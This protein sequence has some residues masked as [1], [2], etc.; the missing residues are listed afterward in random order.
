MILAA[1]GL[2]AAAQGGEA[3][4]ANLPEPDGKP[5]RLVLRKALVPLDPPK[6]SPKIFELPSGRKTRFEFPWITSAFGR[7]DN[8]TEA[9]L[10]MRVYSQ[11]RQTDTNYDLAMKVARMAIRL[12]DLNMRKFKLDHP[13][14]NDLGLV[15][16]YL[17][18]GGA[19]G[20]EQMFGEEV[21][22]RGRRVPVNTIYIYDLATFSQP[23]EMAREVAHEYGHAILPG[24]KGFETPEDWG[25]GYLGEK[26]FLRW[27]AV[28][29]AAGRLKPIDAMDADAAALQAWVAANC[30]PLVA[31]AAA[32]PP[33]PKLLGGKGQ[34]AMDAYIGLALYAED[35]FGSGL[36]GRTIKLN[37][38]TTATDFPNALLQALA[39][40]ESWSAKLPA[41]V[42]GPAWVPVGDGKLSGA[43]I[44]RRQG[45]WAQVEGGS[46]QLKFPPPK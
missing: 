42:K 4:M 7:Q 12:W 32:N 33:D 27:L 19:P 13:W 44:L 15:D 29:S 31:R 2:L 20:G 3:M 45:A 5:S 26:L 25:N 30:D 39:E 8:E 11:E 18:W 36:L 24:V 9:R 35:L 40:R 14:V 17:C 38:S 34:P 16:W 37:G 23:I 43:K 22:S 1:L 46:F 41:S 28:E 6:L 21:D 10:R